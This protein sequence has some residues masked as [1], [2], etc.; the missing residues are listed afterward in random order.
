MHSP[1]RR[2]TLVLCTSLAIVGTLAS[3]RAGGP[4]KLNG[5]VASANQRVGHP[6][7]VVMNG[8]GLQLVAQGS[9]PLENPSGSITNF[10]LLSDGTPTEPDQNVYLDFPENPGGP[11]DYDYGRHFLYQGHENGGG[12]SPT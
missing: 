6:D 4:A 8:F 10:G 3:V 11:T 1:I 5:N 12:I 2:R 9:E 7:N